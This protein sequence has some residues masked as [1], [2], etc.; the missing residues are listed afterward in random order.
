MKKSR[1]MKKKNNRNETIAFLVRRLRCEPPTIISP[2]VTGF[3]LVSWVFPWC[4]SFF[5][6]FCWWFTEFYRIISGFNK[7]YWVLQGH[8]SRFPMVS[9]G[10]NGIE[11]SSTFLFFK[12]AFL[13]LYRVLP[14]LSELL[15]HF[16][17]FQRDFHRFRGFLPSFIQH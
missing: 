17:H 7:L 15:P 9:V 6:R 1:D 10:L 3:D 12:R 11:V 16:F 14:S 8:F 13:L 4:D 2:D 5:R